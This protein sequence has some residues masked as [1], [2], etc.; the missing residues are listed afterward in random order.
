MPSSFILPFTLSLVVL[1][2][3]FLLLPA[4]LLNS[5][6]AAVVFNCQLTI[7]PDGKSKK[8]AY[9]RRQQAAGRCSRQKKAK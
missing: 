4:L 6:G 3:T 8:Y 7:L 5:P 1:A 2:S 9:D